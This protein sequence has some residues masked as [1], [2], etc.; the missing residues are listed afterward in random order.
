MCVCIQLCVY[1]RSAFNLDLFLKFCLMCFC[2]IKT[3]ETSFPRN[4]RAKD[5]EL[6][7]V[8]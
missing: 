6:S 8:L 4:A 7:P 5:S 1:I 2:L 3:E